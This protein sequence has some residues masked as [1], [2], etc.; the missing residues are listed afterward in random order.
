MLLPAFEALSVTNA[1]ARVL[2][3]CSQLPGGLK[4]SRSPAGPVRLMAWG[5]FRARAG[6][7]AEAG[8][9]TFADK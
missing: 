4:A 2:F 9:L 8:A 6:A 5:V 1:V 7:E 3:S